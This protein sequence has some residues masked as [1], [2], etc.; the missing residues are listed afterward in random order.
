MNFEE[1]YKKYK[2]GTA[3]DEEKAFVESEIEKARKVSSILD[4]EPGEEEP[5]ITPADSATVKKAKKAFNFRTTLKTVIIT[6]VSIAV[7]GAV[8]CGVIFGTAYFSANGSKLIAEEQAV[9]LAKTHLAEHLGG[10]SEA[11]MIVSNTET[12]LDIGSR[13]TDSVYIYE[14]SIVS[15]DYRYQVEV[16][17]KTGYAVLADKEALDRENKSDKNRSGKDNQ[18]SEVSKNTGK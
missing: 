13:L 18:A 8:V 7:V 5:V 11:E 16:S 17:S 9:E 14:I 6:L 12:E 4:R 3:T 10:A 1:L 15:G 2:D